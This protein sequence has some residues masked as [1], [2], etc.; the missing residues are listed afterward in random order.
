VTMDSQDALSVQDRAN[1][2]ILAC[3]ARPL[4]DVAVD[5]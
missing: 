3:Q 1:G 2:V 4:S 5:A